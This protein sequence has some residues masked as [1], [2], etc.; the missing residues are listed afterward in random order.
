MEKK[1]VGIWIRVST[2]MQVESESPQ[3]HEERARTYA[4][5]KNWDVVEVYR[6]DGVSGKSTSFDWSM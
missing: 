2:E 4:K 3:V 5:F 1:K 6:L